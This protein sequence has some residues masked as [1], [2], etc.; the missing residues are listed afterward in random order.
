V[1]G[2]WLA[3]AALLGASATQQSAGTGA[4]GRDRNLLEALQGKATGNQQ[5]PGYGRRVAPAGQLKGRRN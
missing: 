2:A 1:R 4:G 5:A 3:G